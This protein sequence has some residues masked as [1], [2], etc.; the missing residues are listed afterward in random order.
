MKIINIEK[1]EAGSSKRTIVTLE[2]QFLLF[3]TRES[4][5]SFDEKGPVYGNW[6]THPHKCYVDALLSSQLTSLYSEREFDN[7][8]A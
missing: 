5:F 3:F 8:K 2:K 7:F 6:R 1:Q 4:K